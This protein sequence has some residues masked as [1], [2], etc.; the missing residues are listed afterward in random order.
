[1]KRLSGFTLIELMVA[2]SIFA[3]IVVV[4]Y[5]TFGT[6]VS[7]WRKT[8]KMQNLY[9]DIRLALD[10][11][12][13]D[14]ENAVLYSEK[15]EFSNF[16]GEKNRISF[17][18]LVDIF[19]II[20]AHP[21]LRKITYS[22]DESTHILQRLEQTFPESMQGSRVQ[23]AEGIVAQVD[24]L[25]FSYCYIDEGAAPSYKWKDTWDSK[26]GIPQGVK[27]EL[28]IDTE[29]KLVFVKHVFIP[30]GEKVRE[31]EEEE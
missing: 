14:L 31:E 28:E 25:N 13:L 9:Q 22:L 11:I 4:I 17:Y 24:N 1:M 2:V 27:I 23:E 30:S 15:E 5:S 6:G 7:V 19:Q 20:P 26:Q 29:E 8:E 12:A 16:E 21:E 3:I 10:K 18:S